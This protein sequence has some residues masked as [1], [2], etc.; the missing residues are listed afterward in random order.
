MLLSGPNWERG[1]RLWVI[2][3]LTRSYFSISF[4]IW[5]VLVQLA[6]VGLHCIREERRLGV[7]NRDLFF[8]PSLNSAANVLLGVMVVVRTLTKNKIR[9]GLR[10]F[11]FLCVSLPYFI[12]VFSAILVDGICLIIFLEPPDRCP[13]TSLPTGW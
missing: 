7:K 8:R 12:S 9:M 1:L 6:P 4:T 11:C 10:W 3:T 5:P 2:T 13:P